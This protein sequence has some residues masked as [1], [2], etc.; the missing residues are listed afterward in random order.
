M[1]C[2]AAT[3]NICSSPHPAYFLCHRSPAS[4]ARQALLVSSSIVFSISMRA[5]DP[6]SQPSGPVHPFLPRESTPHPRNR[7]IASTPDPRA[8]GQEV[9]RAG[10]RRNFFELLRE[11]SVNCDRSKVMCVEISL[12]FFQLCGF[13][14]K[15]KNQR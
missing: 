4:A 7:K 5:P 15:K 11:D 10:D 12:C 14:T 2:W 1:Q 9:Q 8:S 6:S 13:Q 3:Q